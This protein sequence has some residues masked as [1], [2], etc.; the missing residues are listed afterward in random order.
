MSYVNF[1]S[2]TCNYIQ[3]SMLIIAEKINARLKAGG[4]PSTWFPP[5]GLVEQDISTL[6]KS[7]YQPYFGMK[8]H[9]PSFPMMACINTFQKLQFSTPL[10]CCQPPF[11]N[12][13]QN[14]L[15]WP[16]LL[17][18]LF[19]PFRNFHMLTLN[20]YTKSICTFKIKL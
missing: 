20:I 7:K 14:K 2:Q 4:K 19:F 11:Q 3:I 6:A 17:S 5:G 9:M 16:Q 8:I 13:F 10:I 15:Q 18:R 1:S 12:K